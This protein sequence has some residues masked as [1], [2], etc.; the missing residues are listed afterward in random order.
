MKASSPV[1][2]CPRR[3]NS[4][5]RCEP[6]KPAA[7]VTMHFM[8]EPLLNQR[9]EASDRQRTH[10]V[11][12]KRSGRTPAGSRG[13]DGERGDDARET[14]L[15]VPWGVYFVWLE[16]YQFKVRSSPSSNETDGA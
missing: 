1:T 2:L 3:S 10:S 7:P 4:S 14:R 12:G 15:A 13:A 11:I 16:R 9:G 5:H 8:L 6:M